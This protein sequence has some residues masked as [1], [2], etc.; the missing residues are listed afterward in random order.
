MTDA[1]PG[2]LILA[3]LVVALVIRLNRPVATRLVAAVLP[4]SSNAVKSKYRTRDGQDDYH[5]SFEQQ[6]DGSWRVYIEE[7]PG[8]RG[9]ADDAHTTHRLSDGGRKY[10]CWTN[11]L[12]TLPE[13]KQV[14]AMWADATQQYIRSGTRF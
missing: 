3:L 6:R 7:Q 1:L 5:L 13:A 11:P 9:R 4:Q 10:I 12:R 14:A 8:Y 2:L